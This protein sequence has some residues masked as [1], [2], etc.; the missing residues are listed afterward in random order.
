MIAALALLLVQAPDMA[1]PVTIAESECQVLWRVENRQIA[2]WG[3][4]CT[5]D[6]PET[7]NLHE[8]ASALIAQRPVPFDIPD[9]PHL[10]A[11]EAITLNF[12]GET[13]RLVKPVTLLQSAPAYPSQAIERGYSGRCAMRIWVDADAS[14]ELDAMACEQF[15]RASAR[16]PSGVFQR[17]ARDAFAHFRWLSPVGD[18]RRC[19][20]TVIDFLLDGHV[21][22]EAP[23]LGAPACPEE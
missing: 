8:Y 2:E 18:T 6:V 19:T 22:P 23:V 12:D 15:R 11:T 13:W 5:A 17:A 9:T 3:L 4:D 14:A 1:P 20:E 10:S 16:S 21:L 7:E